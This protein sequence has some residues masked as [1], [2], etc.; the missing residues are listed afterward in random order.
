MKELIKDLEKIA[1]KDGSK[2]IKN[3]LTAKIF[4]SARG[5]SPKMLLEWLACVI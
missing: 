2:N 4:A 3:I 1:Y 5:S